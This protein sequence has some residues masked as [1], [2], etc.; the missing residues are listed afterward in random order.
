MQQTE[1]KKIALVMGSGGARGY[2]HLGA[3]KALYEAGVSV[4]FIVGTSFGAL[5][6]AAF[7]A[8]RDV[9]E[10]EKIAL[11]FGW[12]KIIKMMDIGFPRGII[13]GNKM[14]RF[15]SYLF[16]QKRF[17]E[18]DIPLTVVTTDIKTGKEVL[19]DDGLVSEAVMASS[20]L[21]GIFTPK[22]LN[23][24]WLVDGALV[25]PLPIQ[26]ALDLGAEMVIAIDVSFPIK[27]VSY[28]KGFQRHSHSLLKNICQIPGVNSIVSPIEISK[29]LKYIIP[30]G[31]YTAAD[32]LRI[33]E[34]NE[35]KINFVSNAKKV[36][37]IKPKVEKIHW[38]DFHR[39]QRCIDLGTEAM[40]DS[41]A[42]DIKKLSIGINRSKEKV[43]VGC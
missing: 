9:Y 26:T 29:K 34:S 13:N 10:M 7:S 20:A 36:I 3:L 19:I 21:P 28:L 41:I 5:V 11:E 1:S 17:S 35:E 39:V 33:R 15:F 23:N 16:K 8:G 14:E 24:K 25:N 40:S 2:A 38:R 37:L 31:F 42:S 30:E 18:L 6:G 27:S 12:R 4:D 43:Y 22:R 32:G